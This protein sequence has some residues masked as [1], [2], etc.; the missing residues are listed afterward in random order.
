M[1]ENSKAAEWNLNSNAE[2]INIISH[3]LRTPL[4]IILGAQK[5]LTLN[6]KDTSG[7]SEGKDKFIKYLSSI[8]SNS[9][10]LQRTINNFID[11]TDIQLGLCELN[12]RNDDII[13]VIKSIVKH[14]APIAHRKGANLK[15]CTNAN[16]KNMAFDREK[17]E[18]IILN[19]LSNAI[20]FSEKYKEIDI[21]VIDK[22][23]SILIL[24]EDQGRGIPN[25]K[26]MKVFDVFSQADSSLTRSNEGSGTGLAVV[27]SF[28]ELH[29]G[30]ISVKSKEGKG[31]EVK[32]ELPVRILSETRTRYFDDSEIN[33]I[34]KI[35]IEF[36]DIHEINEE[37]NNSPPFPRAFPPPRISGVC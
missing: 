25:E 27:K 19:L 12:S 4:N 15:L 30:S 10:R 20:K 21:I 6:L 14:V 33:L 16:E 36:S 37:D 9:Y 11:I 35:E 23:E 7:I 17:V 18:R 1:Y 34:Q 5:L 22:G 24:V 28:V 8:R 29:K 32:I 26:L 2:F 13:S 3:E 31:T